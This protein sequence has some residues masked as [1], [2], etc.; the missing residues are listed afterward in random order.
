MSKKESFDT[1]D[2]LMLVDR[3]RGK[4]SIEL[5]PQI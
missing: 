1:I 4:A 2:V 3:N 5:I